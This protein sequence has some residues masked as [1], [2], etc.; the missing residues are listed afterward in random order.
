MEQKVIKKRKQAN[1]N[2]NAINYNAIKIVVK[3]KNTNIKYNE[4]D[5]V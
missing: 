5:I 3:K 2:N 4:K 1:N